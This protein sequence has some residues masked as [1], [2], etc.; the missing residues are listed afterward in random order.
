M[1]WNKRLADLSASEL[2][3]RSLELRRM[4]ETATTTWQHD[5]LLRAAERIERCLAKGEACVGSK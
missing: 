2:E 5:A 1:Q 4:A 3:Q